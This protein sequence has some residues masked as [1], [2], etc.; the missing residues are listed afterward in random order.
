MECPVCGQTNID[1]ASTC[2]SCGTPLSPHVGG[3]SIDTEHAEEKG[4]MVIAGNIDFPVPPSKKPASSKADKPLS[5]RLPKPSLPGRNAD[6]SSEDKS[7]FDVEDTTTVRQPAPLDLP[8]QV[9]ETGRPAH[10]IYAGFWYRFLAWFIDTIILSTASS[11]VML[12]FMAISFGALFHGAPSDSKDV[13]PETALLFVGMYG[14]MY[15]VIIVASLLYFSLCESSRWQATIGKLALGLKVTDTNGQR[16]S[17]LRAMGRWFA[18]IVSNV[19][20]L[21]GYVVNVF[22]ARQQTL[23]DMLAGTLV[24]YKEVTPRDLELNPSVPAKGAQKITAIAAWT[25]YTL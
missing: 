9:T 25:L 13:S 7:P 18:H 11:V 5:S 10:L 22:T 24:V 12:V 15:L 4:R 8:P 3:T 21:V 20:L 2:L 1:D 19:T 16:L 17:F 23:H 14:V 6:E